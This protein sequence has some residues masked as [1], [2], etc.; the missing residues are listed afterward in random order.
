MTMQSILTYTFT[1]HYTTADLKFVTVGDGNAQNGPGE[2]PSYGERTATGFPFYKVSAIA[3]QSV[4]KELVCAT[5]QPGA[6]FIVGDDRAQDWQVANSPVPPYSGYCERLHWIEQFGCF[7]GQ[8]AINSSHAVVIGSANGRS[9]TPMLPGSTYRKTHSGFAFSPAMARAVVALV[10]SGQN[11]LVYDGGNWYPVSLPGSGFSVIW[12]EPIGAFLAFQ[13]GTQIVKV[14]PDGIT[15][16]DYSF[17]TPVPVGSVA[18]TFA[19]YSYQTTTGYRILLFTSGGTSPA[20]YSDDGGLNWTACSGMDNTGS[21][22]RY[23]AVDGNAVYVAFNAELNKGMVSLDFG[24]T[25]ERFDH[26]SGN[27]S[28]A[29]TII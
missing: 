26:F 11:I 10:S 25:W 19:A 13:A 2:M 5:R 27:A 6:A 15:W 29:I 28:G 21:V 3:Q 17:I 7:L 9:W 14:S 23:V 20:W 12:H 1:P 8:S 4:S 22:T 16:S 24:A 18:G